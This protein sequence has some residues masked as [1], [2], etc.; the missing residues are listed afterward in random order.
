[1]AQRVPPKADATERGMGMHGCVIPEDADA[2]ERGVEM[3]P[4]VDTGSA[5]AK[6]TH[7]VM[8]NKTITLPNQWPLARPQEATREARLQ[9]VELRLGFAW[10]IQ[11]EQHD[12]GLP[13]LPPCT[14]CGLPTGEYCDLCVKKIAN[15]VCSAC[16]DTDL[17]IEAACRQCY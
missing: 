5:G 13:V 12:L 2:T 10:A 15:P 16:G 6:P 14:W 4:S 1:M 7:D 9:R 11:Q 17:D 3:P 8:G